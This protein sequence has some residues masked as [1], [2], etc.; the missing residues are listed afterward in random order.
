M[1]GSGRHGLRGCALRGIYFL[2]VPEGH[3]PHSILGGERNRCH[4]IQTGEE[5]EPQSLMCGRRPSNRSSA[6]PSQASNFPGTQ[7]CSVSQ[8]LKMCFAVSHYQYFG[9]YLTVSFL[10]PT[11]PVLPVPFV[12]YFFQ[13]K[14][15]EKL[16][17]LLPTVQRSGRQ[18]VGAEYLL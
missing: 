2:V 10:F 17:A 16:R 7:D 9:F 18:Q 8:E 11:F 6:E 4:P 15:A 12:L 5:T 14:I 1:S 13:Q 3:H